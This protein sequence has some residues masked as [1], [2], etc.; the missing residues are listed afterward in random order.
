MSERIDLLVEKLIKKAHDEGKF[1]NLANQGKPIKIQEENPYIDEDWRVAY[2]V[3]ENGGFVPPWV[4]LDK[5]VEQDLVRVQ[6]DRDEHLRW[7]RRR[8][9]EIKN[10][11]TLHFARDLRRLK[12]HHESFLKNHTS[13]LDELNRKIDQFNYICPVPSL[14]KIRF[15]SNEVVRK[16]DEQC[17]AIPTM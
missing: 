4:E 2:K 16:F 14:L 7:L 15:M 1:D 9:H 11:P 10:G 12:T 6:R 5:E 8:L 13:R 3:I 17:P